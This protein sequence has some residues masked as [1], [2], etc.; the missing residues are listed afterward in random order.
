MSIAAH[1]TLAFTIFSRGGTVRAVEYILVVIYA[2]GV[3]NSSFWNLMLKK[4]AILV[5]WKENWAKH[6]GKTE[7]WSTHA[8][9]EETCRKSPI[10]MKVTFPLWIIRMVIPWHTKNVGITNFTSPWTFWN[11]NLPPSLNIHY[12]I[13]YSKKQIKHW[14]SFQMQ[15]ENNCTSHN[16]NYIWRNWNFEIRCLFL[17]LNS[18]C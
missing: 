2:Y 4:Q 17:N 13:D 16:H 12:I 5:E 3:L 10:C 7:T 18:H 14:N 6:T 11:V 9:L 15:M 8:W 1:C